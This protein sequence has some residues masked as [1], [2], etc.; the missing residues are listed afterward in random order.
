MVGLSLQT[1]QRRILFISKSRYNFESEI[2]YNK[3]RQKR[4][5]NYVASEVEI[6]QP[7]ANSFPQVESERSESLY[8]F[9][10]VLIT[11]ITR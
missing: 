6:I 10:I 11:T 3:L 1:H 4:Y 8:L 7:P 9:Y 5:K 2:R